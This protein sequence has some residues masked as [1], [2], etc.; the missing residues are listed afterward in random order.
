MPLVKTPMF[1]ETSPVAM[2]MFVL[3]AKALNLPIEL[4]NHMSNA[5]SSK[6]PTPSYPVFTPDFVS[7]F[8]GEFFMPEIFGMYTI[9]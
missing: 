2:R 9:V 5:D 4:S 7:Y 3:K 6:G 8:L 1:L